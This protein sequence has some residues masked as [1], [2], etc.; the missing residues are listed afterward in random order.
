M[1][2]QSLIFFSELLFAQGMDA[3][4]SDIFHLIMDVIGMKLM[5][6]SSVLELS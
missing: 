6:K 2:V 1:V 3:R 4:R 5:T